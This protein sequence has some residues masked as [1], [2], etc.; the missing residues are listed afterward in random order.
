MGASAA[1]FWK[2]PRVFSLDDFIQ[3]SCDACSA[4]RLRR[5]S[6]SFFDGRINCCGDWIL[7]ARESSLAD[8][9]EPSVSFPLAMGARHTES[10]SVL[11]HLAKI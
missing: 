8:V 7:G 10:H 2:Q 11:G 9:G 4:W 1:K 6:R 5:G 3:E